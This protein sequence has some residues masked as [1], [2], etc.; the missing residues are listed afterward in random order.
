MNPPPYTRTHTHVCQ[1]GKSIWYDLYLHAIPG[2]KTNVLGLARNNYFIMNRSVSTAYV[3]LL[4]Q[5]T[6][7][8]VGCKNHGYILRV[9]VPVLRRSSKLTDVLLTLLLCIRWGVC[10]KVQKHGGYVVSHPTS[11]TRSESSLFARSFVS[12]NQK[13]YFLWIN[14]SPNL[15]KPLPLVF[16][17]LFFFF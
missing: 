6:A 4:K 15:G 12:S 9:W 5:R 10:D 7:K 11:L 1:N 14:I 16:C 13:I 2:E 8:Y 17:C 3:F